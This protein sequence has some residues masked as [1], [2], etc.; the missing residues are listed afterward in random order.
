MGGTRDIFVQG[1][2]AYVASIIDDGVQVLDISGPTNI[3]G[4]A[5][6]TNT[7]P[8]TLLDGAFNRFLLEGIICM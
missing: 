3:R 8:G 4:V 5:S 7:D 1:N 6:I 2:Y